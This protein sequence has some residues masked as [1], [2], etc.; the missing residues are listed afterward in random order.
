MYAIVFD[1]ET[2][3]KNTDSFS[4]YGNMIMNIGGCVVEVDTRKKIEDFNFLIQEIY[5]N[6]EI[7]KNFYFKDKIENFSNIKKVKF[8]FALDYILEL[9]KKYKI[10]D[11]YAYNVSFDKQS[12]EDTVKFLNATFKIEEYNF[13]DVY[14]MACDMISRNKEEYAIFCEEN[15]RV[16]KAGNY[17][18]NAE[19]M[20]AFLTDCPDYIE[21]HTALED[22]KIETE[23]FF[24]CLDYQLENKCSLKTTPYSFCWKWAQP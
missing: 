23:I 8:Q 6:K 14:A 11:I 21:E 2:S 9:I 10:K 5:D 4:R 19:T 18:T 7:M 20:Y 1:T 15:N 13:K 22:S 16:S 3:N 24:K 12:L 17:L